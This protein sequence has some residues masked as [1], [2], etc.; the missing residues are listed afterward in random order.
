[1]DQDLTLEDVL[2]LCGMSRSYFS[3]SFKKITGETGKTPKQYREK[4]KKQSYRK[5]LMYGEDCH[6][7]ME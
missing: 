1:M 7:S 4:Y 2:H 3:R 5:E 6:G